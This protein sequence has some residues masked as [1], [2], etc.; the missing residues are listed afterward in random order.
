MLEEYVKE[1]TDTHLVELN[2]Q[3]R[4]DAHPEDHPNSNDMR[5]DLYVEDNVHYTVLGYKYFTQIW[6]EALADY[7]K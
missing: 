2:F 3:E 1:Y 5:A 6:R 7:L 4:Y